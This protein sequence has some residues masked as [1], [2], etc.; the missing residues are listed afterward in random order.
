M[1]F[2]AEASFGTGVVIAIVGAVAVRKAETP[3]RRV[4]AMIPLFLSIQQCMEGILWL[5]LS[6]PDFLL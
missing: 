2:S 3:S 4:F 5:S 1:C 6:H